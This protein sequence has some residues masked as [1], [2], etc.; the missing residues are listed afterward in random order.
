MIFFKCTANPYCVAS[1]SVTYLWLVLL[2]G[3]VFAG[4]FVEVS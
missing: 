1:K 3:R 4:Y 2:V